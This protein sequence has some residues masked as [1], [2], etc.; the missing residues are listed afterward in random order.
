MKRLYLAH[1]LALA[2][3]LGAQESDSSFRPLVRSATFDV[4][5]ADQ[6]EVRA[7]ATWEALGH[8]LAPPV[9]DELVRRYPTADTAAGAFALRLEGVRAKGTIP[10]Y[11]AFL[12]VH[13]DRAASR[14]ALGEVFAL[15][16]E[17]HRL[18]GYLDFVR[19]YPGTPEAVV[20]RLHAEAL[21]F[22]FATKLDTLAAYD[23]FTLA[24]PEAAQVEGA[25][26]L[27]RKRLLSIHE[28]RYEALRAE[29][30]DAALAAWVNRELRSLRFAY[31]DLW[32]AVQ[33]PAP[34]PQTLEFLEREVLGYRPDSISPA[35]R[36]QLAARTERIYY[37]V[38]WF[39]P[40]RTAEA[41]DAI[42]A[43]A[44][45]QE[46]MAKLEEIRATLE[47]NREAWIAALREELAAT[48]ATLRTGFDEL[49]RQHRLDRR[50][51]ATGFARVES[52]LG[53]LHDDLV[54]V[55]GDLRG[56][57]ATLTDVAGGIRETNA[58]LGQLD[59]RL[60]GM[61]K[62]LVALHR[63]MNQGFQAVE[64]RLVELDSTLRAGFERSQAI[65]LAQLEVASASLDVQRAQL[66]VQSESL[67]VQHQ[68]LDVAYEALDLQYASYDVQIE[69]L[70]VQYD[71]V[72]L[73]LE[74]LNELSYGFERLDSTLYEG[75]GRLDTTLNVGFA[76]LEDATWGAASQI[77]E[78]NR[79]MLASVQS[80]RKRGGS[81]FKDTLGVVGA[82]APG[83][84]PILGSVAG[85]VVG[86]VLD[87]AVAG[88]PLD[89]LDLGRTAVTAG[90]AGKF[91]KVPIAGQLAGVAYDA[92][93]VETRQQH[94][95]AGRVFG[96][97]PAASG[98]QERNASA[99]TSDDF[100]AVRA[101]L[102]QSVGVPATAL[103]F[104]IERIF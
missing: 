57:H 90:V 41:S 104:A 29:L 13:S 77:A 1:L 58:R 30:D 33:E 54:A 26:E 98:W 38:R 70:N 12:A 60:V 21:A 94:A 11:N 6:L 4:L 69:S 46:L 8:S 43:E 84:G 103:G 50:A 75:F 88:E 48:R 62:S 32:T 49:V 31:R 63:D 15:Y 92:T 81:F 22:E 47:A 78:S 17:Q 45:H 80:Q 87:K 68:T 35:L 91:Q 82:F 101:A 73:Q 28:D 74:T 97:P 37:V 72:E 44:Q 5:A 36:R 39:E 67:W 79:S 65:A 51:L 85:S 2:P 25:M 40:Y 3:L 96:A 24:F 7:R 102:G 83:V 42:V 95:L 20:A 89:P 53:L 16:R 23:D 100:R 55:R 93:V 18:S 61:H 19:R 52:S 27:A 71:S 34:R 64:G 56:L 66:D 86:D 10:A 76:R 99:T 59:E 14:G 9:L